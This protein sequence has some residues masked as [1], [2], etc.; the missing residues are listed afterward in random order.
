MALP[1]RMDTF[2]TD[3]II[4]EPNIG[5][6]KPTGEAVIIAKVIDRQANNIVDTGMFKTEHQYLKFV[7]K[8]LVQSLKK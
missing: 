2:V 1:V 4:I 8:H 7:E 5:I 6:H 3:A